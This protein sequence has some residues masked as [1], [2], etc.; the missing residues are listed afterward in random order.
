LL[1]IKHGRS[2]NR[3]GREGLAE[4]AKKNDPAFLGVC[5]TAGVCLTVAV[6]LTA[7]LAFIG[8][9]WLSYFLPFFAA[10]AFS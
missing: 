3:N 9:L 5:L 6:W 8:R 7:P 10:F 4:N 2:F 1:L